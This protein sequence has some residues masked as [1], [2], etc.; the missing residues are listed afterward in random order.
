MFAKLINWFRQLFWK[1][2]VEI[3]IVGLQNAGKSTLVNTLSSG[4]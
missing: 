4:S 3:S 2:E 1:K